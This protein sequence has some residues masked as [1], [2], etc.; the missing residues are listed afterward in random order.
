MADPANRKDVTR[1][2]WDGLAD[3]WRTAMP[4]E[5]LDEVVERLALAPGR[6][7]LDAGCATGAWS[8]GLAQRGYHVIGV[9]LSPA[10]IER[11]RQQVHELGLSDTEARYV[12][13]DLERLDL[14]DASVDA[15]LCINVIDF[16][17]APGRALV[18]LQRI[19][20]PGGRLLLTTLAAYSPIRLDPGRERW[21]RFLPDPP[22][23][24]PLNDLLPW[25]AEALL[26]EL[27]WE[28]I[29]QR[30]RVGATLRGPKTAYTDAFVSALPDRILQQTIAT[31]WEFLAERR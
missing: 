20:R 31:T 4:D 26:L 2:W 23:V 25:E 29:D 11:A 8:L 28:I 12:V 13:G 21:R 3:Q 15:I 9:D 16:T 14:A 22:E 10:M 5:V 6:V 1:Q 27:G 7:L 24:I 17:P 19:L 30:P 18:E